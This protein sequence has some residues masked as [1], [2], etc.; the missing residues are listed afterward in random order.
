MSKNPFRKMRAIDDKTLGAA[1][2]N[3]AQVLT[4]VSRAA[5]LLLRE[6]RLKLVWGMVVTAALVWLGMR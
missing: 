6:R 2:T 1:L 5:E 4:G 3:H